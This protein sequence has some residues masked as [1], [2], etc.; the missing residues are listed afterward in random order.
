MHF[1]AVRRARSYRVWTFG[2]CYLAMHYSAKRGIAIACRPSVLLLTETMME[3]DHIGWK[4]L[5]IG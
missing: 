2:D 3:Q 1:A 5:K 4:S